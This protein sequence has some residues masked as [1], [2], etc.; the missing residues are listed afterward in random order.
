MR[1]DGPKYS[2]DILESWCLDSFM[3]E[4]YPA[5]AYPQVTFWAFRTTPYKLSIS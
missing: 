5:K 1:T 2:N 4:S 3:L